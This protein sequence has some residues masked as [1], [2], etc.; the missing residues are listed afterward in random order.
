MSA[1][2]IEVTK[3]GQYAAWFTLACCASGVSYVITFN[4]LF[5]IHAFS[6]FKAADYFEIGL[7]L[8]SIFLAMFL[9]LFANTA[10]IDEGEAIE[11]ARKETIITL[12]IIV[13]LSIFIF[14][15]GRYVLYIFLDENGEIR[16][17][18]ITLLGYYIPVVFMTALRL[19]GIQRNPNGYALIFVLLM[20]FSG[21]QTAFFDHQ[22]AT[23]GTSTEDVHFELSERIPSA[24]R[25]IRSSVDYLIFYDT[26]SHRVTMI[27]KSSI[28]QV[29]KEP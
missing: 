10:L 24:A 26:S 13:I 28:L 14:I 17:G 12:I 2:N 4:Y 23:N 6:P 16:T 25:Y 21:V 19:F 3:I 29:R 5:Y 11:I 7:S 1:A 15:I 22:I 27:P 9:L 20:A 18:F 8:K